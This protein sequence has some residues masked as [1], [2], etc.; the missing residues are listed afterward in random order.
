MSVTRA[1]AFSASLAT[2]AA[3][4]YSANAPHEATTAEQTKWDDKCFHC[5]NEGNLFCSTDGLTGKCYPASCEEDTLVADAKRAA[6]GTCTLRKHSCDTSTF[7]PMLGFSQCKR[8]VAVVDP[9]EP[10]NLDPCPAEIVI[11]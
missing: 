9:K 7:V 8:P 5:I 4:V 6:A 1:L 3:A 10:E 2:Y 11:S